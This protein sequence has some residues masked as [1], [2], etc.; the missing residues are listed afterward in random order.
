MDT[1]TIA[2]V[3]GGLAALVTAWI[4]WIRHHS[5]RDDRVSV[6]IE[7]SGEVKGRP[8]GLAGSKA[9]PPADMDPDD[10]TDTDSKSV[11]SN[12]PFLSEGYLGELFMKLQLNEAPGDEVIIKMKDKSGGI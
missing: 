1:A 9:P 7:P 12:A 5:G 4:T 8:D 6:R 11:V 2:A 10:R 3:L